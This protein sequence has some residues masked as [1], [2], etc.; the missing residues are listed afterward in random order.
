MKNPPSKYN[1]IW[2]S[3]SSVGDF[4]KCPRLYYLRN[5]WKNPA[6][7]KVN[8]VSP[9]LS[10][11]SA[12]HGVLEPL[13]EIKTEDR[14]KQ[15]LLGIYEKNWKKYSGK[16]GG[17]EDSET[18]NFFKNRGVEMIKNVIN[19]PGPLANKTVKFYQ[20]DFIPNIY[21]SEKDNIILCGLVD[22]VEYLEKTDSLKVIDF[23]T[24]ERD[25]Q[26]D[27]YQLPIY[28][29]LVESL[30]KRKVD[31]MAYWYL[32][33]EKFPTIK[34]IPE[35]DIEEIK[36]ELLEIGL[37]IKKRKNTR[38]SE[39]LEE[40]FACSAGGCKYCR[41]FELIRN[42]VEN[43]SEIEYIGIGEYKQDLYFIKK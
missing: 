8:A 1:A 20:G 4:L 37:D 7:R 40:N 21:L 19:N 39:K 12:V 15:D 3:H 9:H 13:A 17:F 6:G 16:L 11:G 14:L 42:F 30:Q 33:R 34:T 28:K 32:A 43:T 31:S 41:D 25:E 10:L 38:D 36:K 18:E 24:G 27:S 22:W 5:I 26:E 35:E 29:I 2:L 23:K